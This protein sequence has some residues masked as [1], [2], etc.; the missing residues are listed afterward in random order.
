MKIDEEL[1][2]VK[3]VTAFHKAGLNIIFTGNWLKGNVESLLKPYDLSH[4]QF[5][6]LRILRGRG[7]EPANLQDITERMLDKMSNA[8]RLVEKLRLKGLLTRDICSDNRRKVEIKITQAGLDLLQ[9]LDPIISEH[10]QNILS[11]I[12]EEEAEQISNI[13]DKLRS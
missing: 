13:L 4:Q 8:T 11:K 9:L 1:K 10:N 3:P 6:V 2:F 7:D 12:T 5:N